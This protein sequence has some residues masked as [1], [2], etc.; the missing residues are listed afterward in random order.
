M[1]TID[2]V[3]VHFKLKFQWV[4]FMIIGIRFKSE[5]LKSDHKMK[6]KTISLECL[7]SGVISIGKSASL[8]TF[9]FYFIKW[10]KYMNEI[11]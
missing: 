1:H 9:A 8:S 7:I 4:T 6:K 5:W 11:I 2:V 3:A 10:Y